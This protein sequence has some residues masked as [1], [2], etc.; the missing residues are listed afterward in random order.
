MIPKNMP[1]LDLKEYTLTRFLV[2]QPAGSGLQA[3]IAILKMSGFEN[4]DIA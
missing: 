4:I 2:W 3:N 1:I